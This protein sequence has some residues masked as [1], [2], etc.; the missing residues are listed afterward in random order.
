MDSFLYYRLRTFFLSLYFIVTSFSIWSSYIFRAC[1]LND[2]NVSFI[3]QNNFYICDMH[4]KYTWFVFDQMHA[5][6]T[7]LRLVT[8]RCFFIHFHFFIIRYICFN[9]IL[10]YD[11]LFLNVTCHILKRFVWDTPRLIKKKTGDCGIVV[12][13]RDLDANI[14]QIWPT[15]CAKLN[16][17][18]S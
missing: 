18:Y 4:A 5:K 15:C 13:R 10:K 1:A 2:F 17:N 14:F 8:R 3:L 9:I 11:A 6:Y 12:R 16:H 7:W